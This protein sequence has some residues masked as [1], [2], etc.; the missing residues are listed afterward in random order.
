MA[1]QLP[2][3]ARWDAEVIKSLTEIAERR[4]DGEKS[5]PIKLTRYLNPAVG[6]NLPTLALHVDYTT[7][8]KFPVPLLHMFGK[9]DTKNRGEAECL[10]VVENFRKTGLPPEFKLLVVAVSLPDEFTH[11]NLS[12][13]QSDSTLCAFSITGEDLQNG[14]P[15]KQTIKDYHFL[16]EKKE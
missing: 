3:G 2:S 11:A 14:S 15:P 12:L 8:V 1:P 7:D 6:T 10:R 5:W 9:G 16:K 13:S 4:T